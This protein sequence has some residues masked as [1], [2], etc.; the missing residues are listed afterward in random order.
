MQYVELVKVFNACVA[1]SYITKNNC[2]IDLYN[3]S[4]IKMYY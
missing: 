3:V 4:L 2:N 1:M